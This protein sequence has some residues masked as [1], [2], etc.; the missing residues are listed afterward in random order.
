ME[1]PAFAVATFAAEV[2][3]ALFVLVEMDT[4]RNEVFDLLWTCA[5]D[6]FDHRLIAKSGSGVERIL[7][8]LAEVVAFPRDAGNSALGV[9]CAGISRVL[10]GNKQNTP[11]FG[12]MQ[13]CC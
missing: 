7:N 8:V 9:I 2:I 11:L 13:G 12:E 4:E 6:T 10:L 5:D 3:P 1:N